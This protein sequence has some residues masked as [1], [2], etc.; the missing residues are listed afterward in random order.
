MP[1]IGYLVRE[2]NRIGPFVVMELFKNISF[3]PR[4]IKI[5]GGKDN[6][7]FLNSPYKTCGVYEVDGLEIR[8]CEIR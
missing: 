6:L 5:D 1:G 7:F 2:E 4:M 3:R 8:N